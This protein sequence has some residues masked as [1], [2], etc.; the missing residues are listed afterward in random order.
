MANVLLR[1][2]KPK[3]K[4]HIG[5]LIVNLGALKG[6]DSRVYR[7]F[8]DLYVLRHD[9]EGTTQIDHVVVSAF[10]IFVIETKNYSGWIFGSENTQKWTQ[11]L[12][13]GKKF[14]FQN[15]LWQNKLHIASLA[16]ELDLPVSVFHSIVY[17]A[18]DSTFKTEMPANV[19]N[20]GLKGYIESHQ[21]I[22]L[23]QEQVIKANALL[24]HLAAHTDRRK[25]KKEHVAG[26]K[27][28]AVGV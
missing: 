26:I 6:L 12:K 18:G 3:I 20:E 13:G 17:F 14:P 23:S 10:G 24:G 11:C 28:R 5:E 7:S 1:L 22:F 4:G 21:D 27:R 9:E 19:I 25:A 15:P 16:K 8:N 2:F